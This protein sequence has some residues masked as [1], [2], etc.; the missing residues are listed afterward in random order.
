[1][2]LYNEVTEEWVDIDDDKVKSIMESILS[3]CSRG[4]YY[5]CM[6]DLPDTKNGYFIVADD[7]MLKKIKEEK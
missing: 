7:W 4:T 3:V 5:I 6:K 2:R 1:M